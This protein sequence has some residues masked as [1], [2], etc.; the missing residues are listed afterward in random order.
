[1][2][3]RLVSAVFMVTLASCGPAES[4]SSGDSVV[5][6]GSS[7]QGAAGRTPSSVAAELLAADRAFATAAARGEPFVALESMLAPDVMMSAPAGRFAHGVADVMAVLRSS[8]AAVGA[9]LEWTPIR[10]GVSADGL[11]GFT[12]GYTTLTRADSTIPGKYLAYWV[13]SPGGWRVSA[14]RRARRPPGD[15]SLG[16][17]PPALP[18]RL[19]AP[20]DAAARARYAA[21][22][23]STERAFSRDA[24]P[25]G[26]GVAFVRYAADDA[27]NMGGP[28]DAAFLFGPAEIGQGVGSGNT[29]GT[30]IVW[31]PDSVRVAS[32]GDLGVTLGFITITERAR[33]P[34]RIPFFTVWRRDDVSQPWR[35]VAE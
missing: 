28:D 3:R 27:M 17:R 14:Y 22:L 35:F 6:G 19:V 30:T 18:P 12:Y 34:R 11:H 24:Q 33:A 20:G 13:K 31:A 29:P 21:E 7:P 1:M 16:E 23:D 2:N 26:L 25:L 15:V 9:L 10:G 8:P 32:S 4:G 5:G